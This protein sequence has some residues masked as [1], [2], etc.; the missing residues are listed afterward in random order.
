MT[1]PVYSETAKIAELVN[2]AAT[3]VIIQADNPD[4]DSIGSAL[5]LEHIIGDLGKQ[6]HLFCGVDIPSYLHYLAGWD[7]IDKELP[8]QFD[9]SIIVDTSAQSLFESVIKTDAWKILGSKPCIIIDHHAVENTIPFTTVALNPVAVATGEVLF[10]LCRQTGWD[11]N[12]SAAEMLA[13]AMMSD[14]LGL[15]SEGT[16]ARSAFIISELMDKGVS[17]AKLENA[18]REMMRKSPELI[19]YK[20]QLLQRIEYFSDNRIA[21]V[22]IPWQENEQYSPLYNPPMLVIDDMRMSTGTDVAI[23]FKTYRDGKI[24]G[25]IRCNYGK[26]IAGKLAAAF[27]GGGHPYASGFKISDGRPFNEVKSE[28]IALAAKLLDELAS[29]VPS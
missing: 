8:K 16:S 12:V 15:T 29:P 11:I 25:K 7:R 14:S 24:T 22:T 5:A 28:C 10:E 4:G 13:T 9:L 23:A 2:A 19:R 6:P 18:R 20:G 27:G 21:T 17:L 3:I 1:A 26:A